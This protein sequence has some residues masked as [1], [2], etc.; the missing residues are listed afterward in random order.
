VRS[1]ALALTLF[2]VA[3]AA[4][5]G[6]TLR[7]YHLSIGQGDG[8]L[9]I[10]PTGT[11]CLV[12]AGPPGQGTATIVP[13]LNQL[14]VTSLAYTVL[15][16]HHDDHYGGIAEVVAGGFLPVYAAYD[17][18]TVNEPGDPWF[19]QYVAAVGAKRA[20]LAPGAVIDLGGGALLECVG[21]NGI[22]QDG[23]FRIVAGAVGEE[24]ARSLALRLSFGLFSEAIC[25]DLTAGPQGTVDVATIMAPLLGDVDVFKVSHHGALD[26]VSPE[27]IGIL[28]PE[29]S[30]ISCA[31]SVFGFPHQGTLNLLLAQPN[32]AAVYRLVQG[33]SAIGGTVVNG[34]LLIETDGSSYTCSGGQ[35]TPLMRTVDETYPPVPILHAPGDVVVSEYMAD[36]AVV[37]DTLGEWI[38]LRNMRPTSIDLRGFAVRDGVLDYV[39]LPSLT[40]PALGFVV[41]GRNAS[42]GVNGGYVPQ[43]VWPT[44]SFVLANTADQI[45]LV[46]PQGVAMDS[47]AYDATPAYPHPV[48]ASVE[49]IDASAPATGSNLVAAV[50]VFG[51]GD[52]GTPGLLNGADLTPPTIGTQPSGTQVCEGAEVELSVTAWGLGTLSYQWRLDGVP[53]P[54]ATDANYEIA[55]ATAASTGSYDVVVTN[56]GGSRTSAAAVVIVDV[57]PAIARQPSGVDAC[58]GALVTLDVSATGPAVAYQ[59]RR[60]ATELPGA[61]DPALVIPSVG[62]ADAGSY[63]V[64]VT[65]GCGSVTSAAALL[66]VGAA[67]VV[68][69][70]PAAVTV[71]PGAPAAFAVTAG[72]SGLSYQWRKDGNAIP[73]A[74]GDTYAIAAVAASDAGTYDVVVAN[75]CGSIESAG[76][77]LTVLAPLV[78]QTQPAGQSLCSGDA[79]ALS[80]DAIGTAPLAYQWRKDGVAIT[81]AI[82]S[83][84]TIAES[85][86]A[87]SGAYDVIVTDAC[88]SL[89]SA[90][91][92]IS[93]FPPAISS[94]TPQSITST[95]STTEIPL[96]VN[97]TC[98]R[99]GSTVFADGFALPTVVAGA[100]LATA[101]LSTEVPQTV[102]PGG[103]CVNV[104]SPT[105]DVSNSAAL[106]VDGGQNAG[107]IRRQPLAPQP[108]TPFVWVLEGGP[109]LAPVTLVA[110][111]GAALPFAP[112]PDAA[113]NLV[114][115][116]SPVTG[117]AG[118]LIVLVD[119]MGLFGPPQGAAYDANGKF[120]C[121]L[122]LYLPD[123][124]L[125][126]N[127]TLQAAYPDPS[128]PLGIRLTWARYPERF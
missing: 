62:A 66:T 118:P 11:A 76:A 117:S 28:K 32:V 4:A 5:G 22:A 68:L 125:G 106:V 3:C 50:A 30:V 6:Q 54:G 67:P 10:G 34:T 103:V 94:L 124:P 35:I 51:A 87:D 9:I 44:N 16:H 57:A 65:N 43:Y 84:F 114:L 126:I 13:L 29:I 15:T 7:V 23:S 77:A 88:S 31:P 95:W 116:V 108:G 122:V 21:A 20:T 98:F 85:A 47:V 19:A 45:H 36:P 104:Q 46:S 92:A 72:G 49:R 80:V 38:E 37:Q 53:I 102:R 71:C 113:N 39:I 70:P 55:S 40:L 48:G 101:N 1:P 120:V 107:T 69:Q 8:T 2:L 86:V 81:G 99:E 96:D 59:W 115:A 75:A 79:I 27:S 58:S 42:P 111:L 18:G 24:N 26:G 97:G 100:T 17:R 121:P 110:D 128:I 63:D 91:A 90:A 127:A 119:G 112:F 14:G 60:D 123:P 25:G 89:P 78:I 73:G 93:I 105:G 41:I 52:R 61:T 82:A 83:A 74:T 33:S 64:V 56:A 12:D 109:P